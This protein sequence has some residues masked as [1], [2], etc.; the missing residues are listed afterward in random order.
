MVISLDF[1][2]NGITYS[3]Y[4]VLPAHISHNGTSLQE[5]SL[6]SNH[7][8]YGESHR[9]ARDFRLLLSL[10]CRCLFRQKQLCLLRPIVAEKRVS[11]NFWYEGKDQLRDVKNEL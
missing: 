10:Q 4:A 7:D 1:R 11:T 5:S 8:G 3:C 2:L 6:R 9:S